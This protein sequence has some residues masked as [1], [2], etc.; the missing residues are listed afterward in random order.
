MMAQLLRFMCR[1][2]FVMELA[3]VAAVVMASVGASLAEDDSAQRNVRRIEGMVTSVDWLSA[4]L[5]VDG[6]RFSVPQGTEIY[7]G[8]SSAYLSDIYVGDTVAVVY[9]DSDPSLPA[10]AITITIAY[11][12]DFPV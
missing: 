11:A 10:R 12:G 5:I 1:R 7:K 3:L 4:I 2:R 6:R 9:D 8:N